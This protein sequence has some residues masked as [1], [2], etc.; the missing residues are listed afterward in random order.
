MTHDSFVFLVFKRKY[1]QTKVNSKLSLFLFFRVSKQHKHIASMS[2][3]LISNHYVTS[4]LLLPY[5][6]NPI[7]RTQSFSAYLIR[8]AK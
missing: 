1:K 2:L 6:T 4:S 3:A 5:H 8:F 7:K